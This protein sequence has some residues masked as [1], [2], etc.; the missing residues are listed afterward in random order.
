MAPASQGRISGG[1]GLRVPC[2]TRAESSVPAPAP[3]PPGIL[4]PQG[5]CSQHHSSWDPAGCWRCF[6]FDKAFVLRIVCLPSGPSS[7]ARKGTG[8]GSLQNKLCD[9]GNL[10]NLPEPQFPQW[11]AS[12]HF[13]GLSGGLNS[14]MHLSSTLCPVPC[15]WGG[16]AHAHSKR[17]LTLGFPVVLTRRERRKV[18]GGGGE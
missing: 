3:Y 10:M 4:K 1:A 11:N 6:I 13:E 8:L 18:T 16:P 12:A 2:G 15:A 5:V 17:P 14:G 9:L 7:T